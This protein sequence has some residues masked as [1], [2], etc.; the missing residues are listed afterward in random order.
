MDAALL[1]VYLASTE[2]AYRKIDMTIRPSTM[3]AT[4]FPALLLL[5]AGLAACESTPGGPEAGTPATTDAE[6]TAGGGGEAP[7]GTDPIARY[8]L[9]AAPGEGA[10]LQLPD[11]GRVFV[12]VG[13]MYTSAAGVRCRRITLRTQRDASR[14]SAVCR[15]DDG[16]TT[17]LEP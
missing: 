8:A 7:K 6:S 15:Q 10:Q 1:A 12:T 17:V 13:S 11:G 9:S 3:R 14:V 4:I 16:W 2:R 5:T